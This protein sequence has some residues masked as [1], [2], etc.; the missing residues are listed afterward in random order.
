M[1]LATREEESI[2]CKVWTT[3]K[4]AEAGVWEAEVSSGLDALSEGKV[5]AGGINQVL[6]TALVSSGCYN[7]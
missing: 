4:G 5:V 6:G 3:P 1:L 7:K 2:F